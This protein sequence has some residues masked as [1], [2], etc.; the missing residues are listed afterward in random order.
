MTTC[1]APICPTTH[2][3]SPPGSRRLSHP[4]V[5]MYWTRVFLIFVWYLQVN[6]LCLNWDFIKAFVV[7]C[8]WRFCS[9]EIQQTEAWCITRWSR[10][11]GLWWNRTKRTT[12]RSIWTSTTTR[13]LCLSRTILSS[14]CRP[15]DGL[16]LKSHLTNS[17]KCK[18]CNL[19]YINQTFHWLGCTS[20]VLIEHCYGLI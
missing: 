15:I 18:S 1:R 10:S 19:H 9:S 11:T 17:S 12:P 16:S 7:E 20:V 8:C 5:S 4:Y 3:Q 13:Q 6:C 2:L 14:G